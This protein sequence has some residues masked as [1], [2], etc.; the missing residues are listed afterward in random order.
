[1]TTSP[2]EKTKTAGDWRHL[3]SDFSSVPHAGLRNEG[4]ALT[5][6]AKGGEQW[7]V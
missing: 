2:S 7:F 5:P 1:M 3:P 6:A 4:M